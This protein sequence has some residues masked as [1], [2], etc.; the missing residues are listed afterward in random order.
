LLELISAG[1]LKL[2]AQTQFPLQRV[3]EAFEALASRR[4]VGKVVLI[5][6][7]TSETEFH[8]AREHMR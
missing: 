6:G 1:R 4:T 8:S 7:A 5:P 3:R 2:F